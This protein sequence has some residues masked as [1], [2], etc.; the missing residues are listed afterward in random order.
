VYAI[1]TSNDEA[2]ASAEAITQK[3]Q[4]SAEPPGYVFYSNLQVSSFDFCLAN[5]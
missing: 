1:R 3:L 5:V 2:W 4:A